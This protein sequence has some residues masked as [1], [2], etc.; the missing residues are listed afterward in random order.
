MKHFTD[1][2]ELEELLERVAKRASEETI[3]EFEKRIVMRVGRTVLSKVLW[4]LG[5]LI[6]GAFI[7]GT[8]NGWLK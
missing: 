3:N 7:W 1:D 6:V 8:T 5:A 4:V 2:D